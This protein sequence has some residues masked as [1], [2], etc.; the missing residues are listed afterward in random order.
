MA[1]SCLTTSVKYGYGTI[2]QLGDGVYAGCNGEPRGPLLTYTSCA[3][4]YEVGKIIQL[5]AVADTANGWEVASWEMTDSDTGAVISGYFTTA[6]AGQSSVSISM[7][8][9]DVDV[10]V[11]FS[12]PQIDLI[13]IPMTVG[14]CIKLVTPTSPYNNDCHG[15]Q[16]SQSLPAFEATVGAEPDTNFQIESWSI[17]GVDQNTSNST[18]PVSLNTT[19][20]FVTVRVWFTEA[21]PC[22]TNNLSVTIIGKGSVSPP[23]GDYCEDDTL[24]LRPIP[25]YGYFFKGWS[26]SDSSITEKGITLI[27]PMSS[28]RGV[29]AIF[30]ALPAVEIP[31]YAL[32][33]CPSTTDKSNVVSFDFTNDDGNPSAYDK[34][35][36]R[37]NFYSDSGRLKLLYS[38][39]SLADN[40]RWFYNDSAYAALPSDGVSVGDSETI[41]IVYDP[42]ILPQQIT[43]TQREKFVN[44]TVYE[45]PLVCGVKY[46]VEVE[47]YNPITGIFSF[48]KTLSIILSC[49]DVDSYYW[50][51]NEDKNN[52]LCSGQGKVDI[53]VSSSANAQSIFSNVSSNIH[54]LF[55][56]VWQTRRDGVNQVYGSIWDSESDYFYSSGQ[57]GYDDLKLKVGYD[58]IVFADPAANFYIAGK[59][60]E[61]DVRSGTPGS[62]SN[63]I[64]VNTCPLDVSSP[65]APEENSTDIFAKLCGP[66]L[67]TYL[68]SSYDKIKIRIREEDVYSSLVVNSDKI[69]PV[70]KKKSF[71]LDVDGIEGAYA[72]RIRNINDADWGGWIN[73]DNNLYYKGAGDTVAENDYITADDISHDAYRID[74]SRFIVPVDVDRANGLKRICCQVL[75]MYGITN[76]FC[77]D[78]FFNFDVPRHV[79]EFYSKKEGNVFSNP[80]PTYNG[81]YILSLKDVDGNIQRD[82]ATVY[83]KVIFSEPIYKNEETSDPYM[84]GDLKYNVIKQG[85]E[86]G[87]DWK[88]NL[89][90]I[91]NKTFWGSFTI[92]PDDGIFNK[93]GSSFI[94]IVFPETDTSSSCLSDE[95]DVYNSMITDSRAAEYKDLSPED[96]YKKIQTDSTGKAFDINNF[97]QYYDQDDDNFKFGNPGYFRG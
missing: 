5:K 89:S 19:A 50:N 97:K 79:F 94:E 69:V 26:Y 30:E 64:Y 80:F 49:D 62:V 33:Y 46:Y 82:S 7:P 76:T 95:S 58:P 47:S 74:N 67:D 15:S 3:F 21:D 66:G 86:V 87:S 4:D 63:N 29:T 77:L 23:A 81:Q 6:T 40:K 16:F 24:V 43:E 88:N 10:T 55:Q 41:N 8:P 28:N 1:F 39:S 56:M 45:T 54:G 53:Q 60:T 85:I 38:A 42:E 11:S 59:S 91:D 71:R 31:E 83:F 96:I 92:S 61:G 9:F 17:D 44:S 90:V 25:A 48:V 75:T 36:F 65:D 73:I 51:H 72:V 57:G 14:G 84:S 12:H 93:D 52:W 70:V 34:F 68:G 13:L 18:I 20:S 27:V 2:A 22:D 32:F 35:H 78:I 37:V